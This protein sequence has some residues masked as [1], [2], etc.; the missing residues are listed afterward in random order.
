MHI[1]VRSELMKLSAVIISG[2]QTVAGCVW[3][4]WSS[5]EFV[6]PSKWRLIQSRSPRRNLFLRPFLA[7]GVG[8]VE[9]E[10]CHTHGDGGDDSILV[11]GVG[12]RGDGQLQGHDGE[13][14]AGRG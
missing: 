13:E 10:E 5:M 4:M 12:S 11:Q 8:V 7:G 6:G 3:K 14:L 9:S 2:P 1:V